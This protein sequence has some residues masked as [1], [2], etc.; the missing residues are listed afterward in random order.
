MSDH[1][2]TSISFDEKSYPMKVLSGVVIDTNTI[3]R[4]HVHSTT[5]GNGRVS[6][7]SSSTSFSKDI[8]L[9]GESGKEYQFRVPDIPVR[10]GNIISMALVHEMPMI[11]YNHKLENYWFNDHNFCFGARSS[12]SWM[13]L[14]VIAA[15]ITLILTTLGAV[16]FLPKNAIRDSW[17]F[18]GFFIF[19]GIPIFGA[20][21][22][23]EH[24]DT[25]AKGAKVRA[26]LK[27]EFIKLE[28]QIRDAVSQLEVV[29][30]PA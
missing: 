16:F 20:M 23:I 17:D 6:S 3:S 22:M 15:F 8:W 2:E 18:I 25:R 29:V 4:T 11:I 26:L 19:F 7:V 1:I 30:N 9:K 21:S 28:P 12:Q 5:T 10:T 27:D 14:S 24:N 13:R